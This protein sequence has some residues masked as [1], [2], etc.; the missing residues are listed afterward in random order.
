MKVITAKDGH[1]LRA[2]AK[3]LEGNKHIAIFPEN[4]LSPEEQAHFLKDN[5]GKYESVITFSAFIISDAEEVS[6][7]DDPEIRIVKGCSVNFVTMQLW[8]RETVGELALA[9]FNRLKAELE[10]VEDYDD[11]QSLIKEAYRLGDSVERVLYINEVIHKQNG[12]A[13]SS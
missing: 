3:S 8:R 1:K 6:V 11:L 7:I 9:E 10:R 2:L 12:L 13:R 4:G 5:M